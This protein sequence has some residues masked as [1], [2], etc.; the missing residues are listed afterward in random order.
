MTMKHTVIAVRWLLGAWLIF[1][2]IS[3]WLPNM[4]MGHKPEA[5][6]LMH[7]LIDTHVML[8]VKLTELGVGLALLAGVYVPLALVVGFPVVLMVAYVC[9]IVEWPLQRPMIGGAA[10]LAAHVFLLFAYFDRYRPMLAL[11]PR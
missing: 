5:I 11:R 4:P 8:L 9:L 7:V 2:G 10:T 1:N 6:A 3:Y